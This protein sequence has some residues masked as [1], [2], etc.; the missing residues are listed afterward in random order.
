MFVVKERSLHD[1]AH[2]V[3]LCDA[4]LVFGIIVYAVDERRANVGQLLR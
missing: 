1:G 4:D 2:E 3:E